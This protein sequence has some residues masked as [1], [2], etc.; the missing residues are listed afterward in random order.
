MLLGM[1]RATRSQ[2]R[3]R[4]RSTE[5]L[6]WAAWVAGFVV[7]AS[8]SRAGLLSIGVAGLIVLTL[9]PSARWW[10][11]AALFAV[12]AVLFA[13]LDLGSDPR[14]KGRDIAPDQITENL[15]SVA[16][17]DS[18]PG[19]EGTKDWRLEWWKN[20]VETTLFGEYFWLGKGYGVSLAE[21]YDEKLDPEGTLRS[22]H[23]SHLTI[24]ARG[25][26]PGLVL[27]VVL[28]G[29]F[30]VLLLRSFFRARQAGDAGWADIFVWVLATWAAFMVDAFFSVFLESPQIG[31]PFWSLFGFG[32]AA[33][34]MHREA[35]GGGDSSAI[36]Q[37]S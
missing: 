25:G 8:Q 19:L 36:G 29:S 5:W 20:I 32:L 3:D 30:A 34:E 27:W 35:V 18:D 7:V 15:W 28:Q 10:K 17:S 26:V 9:R 6:C 1:L 33:M 11:A 2:L 31:I 13:A 16:E 24:L 37:L 21:D 12:A 14:M 23:N 22:P 4:S